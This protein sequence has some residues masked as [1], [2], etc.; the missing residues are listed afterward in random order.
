MYLFIFHKCCT[1]RWTSTDKIVPFTNWIEPLCS[2]SSY[3]KG[4][5]IQTTKIHESFP[6]LKWTSHTNFKLPPPIIKSPKSWHFEKS[7]LRSFDCHFSSCPGGAFLVLWLDERS[8]NS[9][10]SCFL[11][12]NEKTCHSVFLN[13]KSDYLR[14]A[15]NCGTANYLRKFGN[16]LCA[17]QAPVVQKVDSSIR[18]SR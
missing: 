3:I 7:T 4:P 13:L 18:P 14:E 16:S 2:T 6:A 12:N 11:Y 17:P 9:S 5:H 1:C 10:D 15:I 8:W